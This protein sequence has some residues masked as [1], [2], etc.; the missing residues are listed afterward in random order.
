[1]TPIIARMS[2]TK[3]MMVASQSS[4]IFTFMTFSPDRGYREK[5]GDEFGFWRFEDVPL[6]LPAIPVPVVPRRVKKTPWDVFIRVHL[7][8]IFVIAALFV[9]VLRNKLRPA[10]DRVGRIFPISSG[11][12]GANLVLLAS[13][14]DV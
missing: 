13:S 9:I 10:F 6:Q 7:L 14:L 5:D 3:A 1:M 8:A 2:S 12:I 4:F 11:L